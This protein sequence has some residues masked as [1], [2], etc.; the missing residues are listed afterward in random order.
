MDAQQARARAEAF[1]KQKKEHSEALS[2]REEYEARQRAI[3]E[4]TARLRAL[5]VAREQWKKCS[6]TRSKGKVTSRI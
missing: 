4:N 3:S 2:A 5:R 1:F 6:G